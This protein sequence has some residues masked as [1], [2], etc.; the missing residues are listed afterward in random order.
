MH[1]HRKT[2][3]E[4]H[5]PVKEQKM[6]V[7]IW[8]DVMCPYCYI[9]KAKFEK[10]LA[11]FS[12]KNNVEVEFKSYQLTPNLKTQPDKKAEEFFAEET[13]G[14]LQQANAMVNQVTQMAKEVGLNYQ[15]DK[16][17]LANTFNAHRLIHFAKA[18]GK[19]SETEEI[20][21]QSYFVTGK[22]VDDFSTLTA[23]GKEIG[24][25]T[26]ELKTALENGSYADD[27]RADIREAQQAG[28]RGVPFF[29]F[30]RKYAVSG[31]QEENTYLETLKKSFA[32][33]RKENP[34][35]KLE[36]IEGKVC[37]P[38]GKCQ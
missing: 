32:E 26:N 16:V 21:F 14:T 2:Q 23:L 3:K 20:L 15:F 29:V 17:V 27:V 4:Q 35:T 6:K 8:T 13:G 37:K 10:A 28:V 9:G 12:D 38:D 11:Q 24:L 7:E 1:K 19:Q 31:V 25:D 18:K 22:N 36:V 34:E 30:N 5:N 33:W